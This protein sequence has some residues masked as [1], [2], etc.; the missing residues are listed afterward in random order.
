M[1]PS[2]NLPAKPAYSEPCNHCGQ[3]CSRALCDL[4]EQAFPGESAPCR[5]LLIKDGKAICSL[6]VA[7][8]RSGLDGLI[9]RA[10]GIGCG[11]SMP[12][13]S[14]TEA[15]VLEFDRV[16]HLKVYGRPAET[17]LPDQPD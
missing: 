11:C 17:K 6:V 12:D 4:A 16:S 15:E 3:C 9:R 10:L 8:E 7:E 1:N 14:T 13:A 2:A 5:A